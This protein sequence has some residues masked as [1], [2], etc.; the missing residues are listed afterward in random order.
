LLIYLLS[1]GREH[2][3]EMRTWVAF[4]ISVLLEVVST[5]WYY[6]H[7]SMM[8]SLFLQWVAPLATAAV[9]LS[10]ALLYLRRRDEK[11]LF[12]AFFLFAIVHGLLQVICFVLVR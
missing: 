3:T 9:G 4:G 1:T 5:Y 12:V 7:R 11:S 2:L 6:P 8:P 10:L